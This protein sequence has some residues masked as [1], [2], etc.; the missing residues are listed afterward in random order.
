MLDRIV[1]SRVISP[2]LIGLSGCVS[3]ATFFSIFGLFLEILAYFVLRYQDIFQQHTH[4]IA[5]LDRGLPLIILLGYIFFG[6]AAVCVCLAVLAVNLESPVWAWLSCFPTVTVVSLFLRVIYFHQLSSANASIVVATLISLASDVLLLVVIRR[7]LTWMSSSTSLLRLSG[8]LLVQVFLVVLLCYL[9]FRIA[10]VEIRVNPRGA[11]AGGASIVGFLNIPTAFAS[12]S[13]M[14]ALLVVLFHR[15]TWPVLS[16]AVY[17][18]TRSDVLDKRSVI[19]GV[20]GALILYGL[21][22]IP[23]MSLVVKLLR[24]LNK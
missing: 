6:I 20:A 10:F 19:R 7:S 12:A 14:L 5:T 1:G 18:L 17:V 15:A 11:L 9:P 21:S 2:R 8:A 24:L 22:G 13:F 16:K 3:F 4:D 23:G